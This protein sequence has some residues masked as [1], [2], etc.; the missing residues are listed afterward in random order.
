VSDGDSVAM[1]GQTRWAQS[2]DSFPIVS[3]ID[4]KILFDRN[5]RCVSKL[6]AHTMIRVDNRGAL[7]VVITD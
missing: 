4:A 2:W 6:L 3:S 5:H 1:G 7:A